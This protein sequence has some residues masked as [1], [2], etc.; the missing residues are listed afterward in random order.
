MVLLPVEMIGGRGGKERL[1]AGRGVGGEERG[2]V[3]G[4]FVLETKIVCLLYVDVR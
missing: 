2:G 4:F 3:D 1:R